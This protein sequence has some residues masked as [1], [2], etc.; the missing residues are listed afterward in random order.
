MC[1]VI[2]LTID[3]EPLVLLKLTYDLLAFS[4]VGIMKGISLYKI[5][6]TVDMVTDIK[7]AFS[8]S[9]SKSSLHWLSVPTEANPT[10][11]ICT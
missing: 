8:D 10:P 2:I 11:P 3:W 9:G 7:K 1:F 5:V 4:Y 6:N